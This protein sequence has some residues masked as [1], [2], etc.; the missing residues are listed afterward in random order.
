M[1]THFPGCEIA[2]Q[3]GTSSILALTIML[4]ML[5]HVDISSACT[6]PPG[7]DATH[8]QTFGYH[9][10]SAGDL[11][12]EERAKG[13]ERLLHQLLMRCH[14]YMIEVSMCIFSQGKVSIYRTTVHNWA[15]TILAEKGWHFLIVDI[16]VSCGNGQHG[17]RVARPKVKA[18]CWF[19]CQILTRW[20]ERKREGSEYGQLIESYIKVGHSVSTKTPRRLLVVLLKR[21]SWSEE[22]QR[23]RK[24]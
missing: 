1:R 22:I 9:H 3:L 18:A 15:T 20:Q 14:V 10:L 2:R 4:I 6:L 19:A 11:L 21:L 17:C 13:W 5:Y 16:V 12:R 24:Q 23:I 8:W 7:I